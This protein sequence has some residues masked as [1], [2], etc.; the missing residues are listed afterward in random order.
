MQ[1]FKSAVLCLAPLVWPLKENEGY[2]FCDNRPEL[3]ITDRKDIPVVTMKEL[4]P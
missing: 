3:K 2:A 1:G 4:L